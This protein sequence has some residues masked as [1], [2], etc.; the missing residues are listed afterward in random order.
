MSRSFLLELVKN[1][2]STHNTDKEQKLLRFMHTYYY[3]LT[4]ATNSS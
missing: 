4:I 3:Y 2:Y 1:M